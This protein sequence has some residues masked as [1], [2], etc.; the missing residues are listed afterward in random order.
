MDKTKIADAGNKAYDISQQVIGLIGTHPISIPVVL[1]FLEEI[2]IPLPIPGEFFIVYDGY[3]VSQNAISYF[4]IFAML[5][6]SMTL[7]ASILYFLSVRWGNEIVIKLGKYI[8]LNQQKLFHLEKM[9]NQHGRWLIIFGRIIP[10]FRIP[11][12]IFSGM[13]AITFKDF[14]T[15][16]LISNVLL[17]SFYLYLGKIFGLKGQQI[18]QQKY[19]GLFLLLLPVTIGVLYYLTSHKLRKKNNL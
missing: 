18:L 10:G 12:T 2:A 15:N 3:L 4:K 11:I 14:I 13:S 9:F 6:V 16:V 19:S 8:H 1:L 17:I 5:L 7:G